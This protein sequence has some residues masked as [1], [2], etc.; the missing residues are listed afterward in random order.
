M[1]SRP[2]DAGPR[3]FVSP[4]A[5]GQSFEEASDL[6]VPVEHRGVPRGVGATALDDEAAVLAVFAGGPEELLA[7]GQGVTDG[8]PELGGVLAGQF[9]G[10][11]VDGDANLAA[12]WLGGDGRFAIRELDQERRDSGAWNRRT[13]PRVKSY[14]PACIR[15]VTC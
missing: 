15:Q 9:D 1:S 4:E 2:R 14:L 5:I 3:Q 8:V 10:L 6:G 12:V 7:A 11:A 13:T